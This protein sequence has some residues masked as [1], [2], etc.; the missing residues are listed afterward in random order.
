MAY[1]PHFHYIMNFP[2]KLTSG[3]EQLVYVRLCTF[4]L[5]S[6]HTSNATE[7]GPQVDNTLVTTFL[8]Q[9][10]IP[11]PCFQSRMLLFLPLHGNRWHIYRLSKYVLQSP[12]RLHYLPSWKPHEC[13][14]MNPILGRAQK[15]IQGTT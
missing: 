2:P 7:H 15:V 3:V 10:A 11:L 14:Y 5:D 1:A 9:I 13:L 8:W 12:Y 6:S 4:V